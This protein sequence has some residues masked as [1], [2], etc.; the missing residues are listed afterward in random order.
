MLTARPAHLN[1]LTVSCVG[2]LK[3][4]NPRRKRR[5]H[6]TVARMRRLVSCSSVSSA[7]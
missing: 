5:N 7:G 3:P 1:Q 6:T 4:K 2:S